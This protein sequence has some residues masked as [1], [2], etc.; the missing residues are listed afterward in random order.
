[1]SEFTHTEFFEMDKQHFIHPYTDFST[2]QDEGSQVISH[3]EG[4]YVTDTE[5][6]PYLDG[7][8][9]LWCV[10]IGHGRREMAEA[11]S[12]QVT[13][14]EYYNPFGHSTNKPAAQLAAKL[15]ELSPGNLNHVFYGCGGSV[16]NDTAVRLAHYYFNMKGLHSKKKIIS[17]CDGYHG[18]TYLAA[19]L[20]GIQGTKYG[21]DAADNLVEYISAANMYRRPV[22]AEDLTEAQYCDFL[23]DEFENH[24]LQLG[25]DNV[26]AFIAE[27]IMG[28]GGV[29][30]APAGYHKRM[31]DTCKK[32]DMLF[33]AD[34]VV[35]AF[36]RLG[37]M[38]ASEELYGY[39]PDMLCMAKGLTSGYIPL[40]ATMLS[41]E[42]YQVI[43]KPQC[44][45]G[46]LSHGFTYSGHP[47]ACAAALKNIEI[48]EQEKLCEH[49]QEVGPYFFEQAQKLADLPIVGDVRGSHFMV[50]IELV[51]NKAE[52]S[53]FP[54]TAG[55]GQRVFKH[56]QERGVIVRP[57]GDVI[58]L[59]PPLV[60]TRDQT[61]ILFNAL[62]ESIAAVTQELG[63]G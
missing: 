43:S 35:T 19:A 51:S 5:G 27:P 24:I 62:Y 50:G 25:P 57:V 14:M 31:Y 46:L 47:V 23:I 36:G 61:D 28:A 9:G 13:T 38:V 17:R 4:V 7:I 6:K 2:F 37:A 44:E 11:I 60:M 53:R 20:T 55:I 56:C 16:A 63:L 10:N 33:I 26:A 1:M 8:A 18:S 58:V 15:A 54:V 39:T 40:G 29:L 48:M 12:N 41:D 49:V 59:S 42:I 3:S 52:K 45:G 34:E 21:F 32:Y 30:V 22:G